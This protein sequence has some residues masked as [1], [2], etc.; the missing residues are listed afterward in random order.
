MS[1]E[2]VPDPRLRYFQ[3]RDI[4]RIRESLK[5]DTDM[6]RDSEERYH[7]EPVFASLVE[8]LFRVAVSEGFTPGELKQIAFCAALKAEQYA[9]RVKLEVDHGR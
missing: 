8:Y 5:P 1:V 3:K 9:T 4:D 2:D 6:Y 7:R